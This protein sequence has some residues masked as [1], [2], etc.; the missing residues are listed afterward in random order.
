M[1]KKILWLIVVLIVIIPQC[2]KA[3]N[4]R[5][6]LHPIFSFNGNPWSAAGTAW[7]AVK[8]FTDYNERYSEDV[9]DAIQRD[10][11][12]KV[13]RWFIFLIPQRGSNFQILNLKQG[14][15]KVDIQ[16][17]SSFGNFFIEGFRNH[18]FGYNAELIPT[19][20]P[21]GL[22]VSVMYDRHNYRLKFPGDE[23]RIRYRRNILR[24]EAL[25]LIRLGNYTDS[26][27][28][29]IIETGAAYNH[30]FRCRGKYNDLNSVEDGVTIIGGIGWIN[31]VT[32]KKLSLRYRHDNFDYFNKN[33]SPDGI[34]YPYKDLKSYRGVIEFAAN[35]VF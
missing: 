27:L 7:D 19:H 26:N 1:K 5:W 9:E 22:D 25:M 2:L 3:Q 30:V 12:K 24:P 17:Y 14:G 33:F 6:S 32:G 4:V 16:Y 10:D 35:F 13:M 15:E 8:L 11:V 20:F 23:E 18:S 21:L 29:L 34:T 31:T 28:N